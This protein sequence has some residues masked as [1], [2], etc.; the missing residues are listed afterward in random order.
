[1][2]EDELISFLIAKSAIFYDKTL[3]KIKYS[4]TLTMEQKSFYM[5]KV[6][7]IKER[8]KKGELCEVDMGLILGIE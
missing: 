7:S 4:K 3:T 6:M 8:L 1:M 2:S 5:R